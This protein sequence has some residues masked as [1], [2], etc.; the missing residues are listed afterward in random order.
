MP[1]ELIRHIC[2]YLCPHCVGMRS[3]LSK[4]QADLSRLSRTC[5]RLRNVVQPVV[6]HRLH[7]MDSSPARRLQ[8][9][10]VLVARPDLARNVKSLSFTEPGD[11][12]ELTDTDRQFVEGLVDRLGL[13]PLPRRWNVGELSEQRLILIELIVI[14]TPNLEVLEIPLHL[15]WDMAV[16]RD[17]ATVTRPF[18]QKLRRL[19][20]EHFYIDG[21]GY[22]A[23]RYT[24]AMHPIEALLLEAPNL[25]ELW[26]PT[27][28][29][30][31]DSYPLNNL[32]H[33][34]FQE[35]YCT[36]DSVPLRN[37]LASCPRLEI[38][39]LHWG[40]LL[41]DYGYNDTR[42]R[43]AADAWS[44]LEQRIDT[45]REIRLDIVCDEMPLGDSNLCSLQDFCRL[46][47]LKVDL[48]ALGVLRLGLAQGQP[49]CADRQLS[50]AAPPR[51]HTRSHILEARRRSGPCHAQACRGRRGWPVSRSR[52]RGACSRRLLRSR[53]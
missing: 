7:D 36:V 1:V 20:I 53:D 24:V 29:G 48:H 15:D 28:E 21:D 10:G 26:I 33:I 52:E 19:Q 5:R 18:L 34:E 9:L 31:K 17:Q 12:E 22:K 4:G 47:V 3:R 45:L 13:P 42:G 8:F 25:E 11:N 49:S 14:R 39:A 50:R 2:S 46:E 41:T 6:F 40:A 27:V 16:V 23:D 44:A 43:H 35:F 32:R 38:F 51:F 30:F 37:I